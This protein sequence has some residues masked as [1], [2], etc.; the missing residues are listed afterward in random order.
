MDSVET[1]SRS[2]DVQDHILA[3]TRLVRFATAA[4]TPT[5]EIMSDFGS[6]A[7]FERHCASSPSVS[8]SSS[9]AQQMLGITDVNTTTDHHQHIPVPASYSNTNA[10]LMMAM[11]VPK[12][13]LSRSGDHLHHPLDTRPQKDKTSGT[14]KK[15]RSLFSSNRS[16][17]SDNH[18]HHNGYA[19]DLPSPPPLPTNNMISSYDSLSWSHSKS[20]GSLTSPHS[21]LSGFKY[22]ASSSMTFSHPHTSPKRQQ[23]QQ[24]QPYFNAT[25]S[26]P[27]HYSHAHPYANSVATMH[28]PSSQPNTEGRNRSKAYEEEDVN[29]PICLESLSIRLQGEKPHVVPVCG[30]KLHAECFETAYG[31][32]ASP[33]S[34][35]DLA[36]LIGGVRKPQ[37]KKAPIGICGI[38][39]SEMKISEGGDT[40]KSSE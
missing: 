20:H 12:S 23:Q 31:V 16:K 11:G 21:S 24:Q 18:A 6:G 15:A 26:S 33:T 13:S 37:Q 19:S 38:C 3:S 10:N 34:S 14:L 8:R 39:R 4:T 27:N 36:S 9:K 29:C 28:R 2:D 1:Q 30:H 7:S 25:Q 5:T 40:G 32:P 17:S 22:P 35:N